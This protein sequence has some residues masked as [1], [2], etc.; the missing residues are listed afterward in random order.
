MFVR[1][2]PRWGNKKRPKG[3]CPHNVP[4]E[5]RWKDTPLRVLA[6]MAG[7]VPGNPYDLSDLSSGQVPQWEH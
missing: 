4:K 7:P 3:V 2:N 6:W 5:G 1:K